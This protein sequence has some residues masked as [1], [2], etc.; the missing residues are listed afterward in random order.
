MIRVGRCVPEGGIVTAVGPTR[1]GGITSGKAESA[2]S[3]SDGSQK[4]EIQSRRSQMSKNEPPCECGA[5]VR[6]NHG[7]PAV[8]YP[9]TA[10][11]AG[12]ELHGV[13]ARDFYR[14]QAAGLAALAELKAK[15]RGGR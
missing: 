12:Y 1:S 8:I 6:A 9:A 11:R 10:Y 14:A 4:G 7:Q 3:V 13:A 2:V 15:L 5:C